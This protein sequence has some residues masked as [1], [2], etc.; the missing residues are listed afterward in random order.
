MILE[1]KSFSSSA[2][3]CKFVNESKLDFKKIID[4]SSFQGWSG[5][6]HVIW[7]MSPAESSLFSSE[8]KK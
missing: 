8:G 2:D 3:L 1:Y 6:E 4:I 7:Y 5:E